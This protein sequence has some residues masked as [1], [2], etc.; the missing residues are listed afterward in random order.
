[1]L[2][3]PQCPAVAGVEPQS[4][5]HMEAFYEGSERCWFRDDSR[6]FQ[7]DLRSLVAIAQVVNPDENR[8]YLR[9]RMT[10]IVFPPSADLARGLV[11]NFRSV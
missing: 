7:G 6:L 11:R 10:V 8:K 2:A 3:L 4:F 9:T 5:W 1:M